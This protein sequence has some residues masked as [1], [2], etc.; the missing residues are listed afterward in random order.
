MGVSLLP[1]VASF[2]AASNPGLGLLALCAVLL[3]GALLAV[4]PD[5]WITDRRI[6][7][8][9]W[10]SLRS[11]PVHEVATVHVHGAFLCRV[12]VGLRNQGIVTL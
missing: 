4:A 7:V 2:S 10:W 1:G 9:T 8:K 12:R 5:T 6:M 3:L 11:E